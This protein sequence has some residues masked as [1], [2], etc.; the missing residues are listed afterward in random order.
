MKKH[1]KEPS[2]SSD[3]PTHTYT[4]KTYRKSY[5]ETKEKTNEK[6]TLKATPRRKGLPFDRENYPF[7]AVLDAKCYVYRRGA[8]GGRLQFVFKSNSVISVQQRSF[9]S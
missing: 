3:P 1:R 4:L 9:F 5:A 8:E 6:T 7:R 2:K